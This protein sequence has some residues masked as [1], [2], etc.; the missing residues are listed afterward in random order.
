MT[1]LPDSAPTISSSLPTTQRW[2]VSSA[3]MMS[4]HTGWRSSNLQRGADATTCL[5]VDET[6]EVVIDFRRVSKHQHTPLSIDGAA[7]E[8]VSNMKFLGV[9][10]AD[11][12]TSTISTTAVIKKAQQRLHPLRRLRK[13]GLPTLHL[14]TFY[15]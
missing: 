4:L 14:T 15:K 12:L 2:W 10:L 7:V 1:A 8:R 9:H 3:T 6:K 5:N 11:D 13:A